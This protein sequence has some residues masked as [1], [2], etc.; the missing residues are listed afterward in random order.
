MCTAGA[1]DELFSHT[2]SHATIHTQRGLGCV[3]VVLTPTSRRRLRS[4]GPH[5]ARYIFMHLQS[6]TTAS[7]RSGRWVFCSNGLSVE[8][9][10]FRKH[11]V[12]G[13]PK[14][15]IQTL[16]WFGELWCLLQG[17]PAPHSAPL[18]LPL[19]IFASHFGGGGVST[20]VSATDAAVDPCVGGAAGFLVFA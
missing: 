15:C 6:I 14:L 20:S 13:L 12:N 7:R 16:G 8:S 5:A 18:R 17:I 9:L 2:S 11:C 1:M 19:L 10:A 4:A 3:L